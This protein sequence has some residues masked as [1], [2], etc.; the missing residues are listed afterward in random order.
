[1]PPENTILGRTQARSRLRKATGQ[2]PVDDIQ[3]LG[4]EEAKQMLETTDLPIDD[5]A[6]EVGC[7]VSSSFRNAF[8]RHV[9]MPAPTYRRKRLLLVPVSWEGP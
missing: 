9:G 3:T 6:E 5:I 2:T 4:I 1:M 8:R 7:T